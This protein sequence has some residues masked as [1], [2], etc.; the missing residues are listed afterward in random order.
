M[1][2]AVDF[3]RVI[4]DVDHPIPGRTMGPPMPGA[5]EALLQMKRDGH[6]IIIFSVK[7]D[8]PGLIQNW[9]EYWS[10]PYDHITRIKP[11]ADVFIDDKAVKFVSWKDLVL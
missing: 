11:D 5:Q 10:I 2:I 9:M 1:V 8:R 7:G 6:L 4:H 3:D